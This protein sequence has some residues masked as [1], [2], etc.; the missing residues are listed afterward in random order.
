MCAKRAPKIAA[1]AAPVS[2]EPKGSVVVDQSTIATVTPFP[3]Q[4]QPSTPD[5][6]VHPLTKEAHDLYYET[7]NSYTDHRGQNQKECRRHYFNIRDIRAIAEMIER[8]IT[9][10][11]LKLLV[12][13]D[14]EM[15]VCRVSGRKFQPVSWVLANQRLADGILRE[16]A[17]NLAALSH[18]TLVGQFFPDPDQSKPD[19]WA[20]S[21]VCYY[22]NKADDCLWAFFSP[23]CEANKFNGGR[24]GQTQEVATS[25][26]AE[27]T[28]RKAKEEEQKAG[29]GKMADVFA[30]ARS[31]RT[32]GPRDRRQF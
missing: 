2:V 14:G 13:L 31:R 19:L 4:S 16:K 29:L 28:E 32:S 6:H 18:A 24:W 7:I 26:I 9:L 23:L 11:E 17:V 8:Q 1:N 3:V 22:W 20:V 27:R 10:E 25:I 5:Y 15:A 21:G 30:N 12:D